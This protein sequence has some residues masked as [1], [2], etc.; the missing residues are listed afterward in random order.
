MLNL[1]HHEIIRI[2]AENMQTGLRAKIDLLAAID[3]TWKTFRVFEFAT[4]SGL[5]GFHWALGCIWLHMY[6]YLYQ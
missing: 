4:T 5:G 1:S 3:R 2:L 6:V